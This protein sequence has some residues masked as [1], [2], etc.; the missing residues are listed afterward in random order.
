MELVNIL[1]KYGHIWGH[2]NYQ[3][4]ALHHS[5]CYIDL[6]IKCEYTNYYL[7]KK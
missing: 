6:N 1:K 3:V 7:Q 4:S 5:F 2:S